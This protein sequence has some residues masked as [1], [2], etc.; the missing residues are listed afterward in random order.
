MKYQKGVL[1]YILHPPFFLYY[2]D[3]GK[4]DYYASRNEFHESFL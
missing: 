4:V 2:L 1:K 3:Y